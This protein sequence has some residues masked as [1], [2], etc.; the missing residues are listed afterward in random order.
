MKINILTGPSFPIPTVIGGAVQKRWLIMAEEFVNQGH[1]VIIYSRAYKD[2]KNEEIIDGIRHI[3]YG[4]FNQNKNVY[5]DLIKDFFYAYSLSKKLLPADIIITNDFWLPFFTS[6]NKKLGETVVNVGRFPKKQFFLYKKVS[7]IISISKAINSAVLEQIPDYVNKCFIVNNPLN[8]KYLDFDKNYIEKKTPNKILYVGRINKEKGIE[9]LIN[10][11]KKINKPLNVTLTII[12]PYKQEQGGS[13][14]EYL[15]YLKDLSKNFNIEFKEPIFDVE[16][17][18]E[19]YQSSDIFCYPS[20]AEKGE[21]FGI[22]PLEAMATGSISIVSSLEC[23]QDFI[24]DKENGYVFNH[25]AENAQEILT[26]T[27]INALEKNDTNANIRK[28]AI[29]T[30]NKFSAKRIAKD[31]ISVFEK[32]LEKK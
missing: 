15:K 21:A 26:N 2:F 31:Y 18:I 11:F 4:G 1:E 22:A 14:E 19:E 30:A 13:G 12:G 3:R 24:I 27:I 6:R 9:L 20:L 16:K 32:I 29:L 23:F 25:R 17:L 8:N 28:N 7:G 10:S 5:V